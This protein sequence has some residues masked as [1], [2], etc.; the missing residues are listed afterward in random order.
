[1]EGR[2]VSQWV[3]SIS[4]VIRKTEMNL[5]LVGHKPA[6]LMDVS[7]ERA[8]E[9]QPRDTESSFVDVQ[10]ELRAVKSALEK[11]VSET[12]AAHKQ[13]VEELMTRLAEAEVKHRSGSSTVRSK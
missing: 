2:R 13:E 9:A 8:E 3:E 5:S 4:T 11:T 6:Y 10:R 7:V 1:M 12:A